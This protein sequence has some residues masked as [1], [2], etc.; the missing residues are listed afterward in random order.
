MIDRKICYT[1]EASNSVIS[2][3]KSYMDAR[4]S[5]HVT[6]SGPIGV[7]KSSLVRAFL[8]SYGVTDPIT[9]PTFTYLNCYKNSKEESFYHFDLY[10]LTTLDEF[11]QSGFD[12]YLHEKNAMVF[13]EWPEIIRPILPANTCD[14]HIWYDGIDRRCLTYGS[15][16]DD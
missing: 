14:I 6:F 5:M 1:E 12:E 15:I 10:R 7:G 13:I 9:S 2:I 16:Q 4:N 3:I 11:I 8:R